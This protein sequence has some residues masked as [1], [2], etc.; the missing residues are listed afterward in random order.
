MLRARGSGAALY[1][2]RE[3][4][5]LRACNSMLCINKDG[6]Q[7]VSTILGFLWMSE[8]ELGLDPT[9]MTTKGQRFIEIERDGAT[10]QLVLDRV[11]KRASCIAAVG[12]VPALT[13]AEAE[14]AEVWERLEPGLLL[15][16]LLPLQRLD[17]FP[18]PER[19]V[20]VP[21]AADKRVEIAPPQRIRPAKWNL[22]GVVPN[23][24]VHL[25]T[26]LLLLIKDRLRQRLCPLFLPVARQREQLVPVYKLLVQALVAWMHCS[27]LH[28]T[29]GRLGD[30]W[31]CSQVPYEVIQVRVEVAELTGRYLALSLSYHLESVA[32]QRAA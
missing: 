22:A 13:D 17:P 1:Q 9:I 25:Q 7:F 30:A 5:I 4:A 12:T 8:E 21:P 15:V 16:R 27:R 29:D 3:C 2:I 19:E 31:V 10:E 23:T 28:V 24:V 26:I 20:I 11:M 6:L 14:L 18:V 32:H